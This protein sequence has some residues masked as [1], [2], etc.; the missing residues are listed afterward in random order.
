M[1]TLRFLLDENVDPVLRTELLRHQPEM[2]V[3]RIGDPSTPP[4]GTAD[5]EILFWCELNKFILITN[6]RKSMPRHLNDHLAQD[7]HVPGIF[8]LSPSMSLGEVIEELTLIWAVSE[9]EGFQ[10]QIIYL[11]LT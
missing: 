9:P 2:I 8:E 10:D 4:R 6:N 5:P 11:P 7:R 3:W 1:D